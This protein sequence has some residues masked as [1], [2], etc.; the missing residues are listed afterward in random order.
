[1]PRLFQSEFTYPNGFADLAEDVPS[2]R[3]P[4]PEMEDTLRSVSAPG[5][6]AL[7]KTR[8]Q[9]PDP[10]AF[11]ETAP[12]PKP[13]PQKYLELRR[14]FDGQPE[15]L[16]LHALT[17]AAARRADPPEIARALFLE[18]WQDHAPFL[19]D[20]LDRRWQL[21][22]LQTFRDFGTNEDQRRAA[23]ELTVFFA[24]TKLYETERLYSGEKAKSPF[25]LDTRAR[26]GLPMGLTGYSMRAGDLDRTLLGM[27]WQSA[28]ADPVLRPL[29]CRLL[30]DLNRDR[31][32]LFRR[33]RLM[34]RDW[35]RRHK[36]K[37]TP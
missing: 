13:A 20:H 33:L 26:G 18:M 30:T 11:P 22:A 31:S 7:A 4:Y 25:S 6:D 14:E 34:R 15:L 12:T 21:S 3:L 29:A 36:S 24:L 10:S 28:E 1:M 37:R 9:A 27:L 19:L 2:R 5:L 32:S 17:I 23:S 35:K 8:A 16:A